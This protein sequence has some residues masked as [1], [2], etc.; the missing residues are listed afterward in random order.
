MVGEG[1][2][3]EKLERR[4]VETAAVGVSLYAAAREGV[5]EKQIFPPLS[6]EGF[7][8][9]QP[10]RIARREDFPIKK[11]FPFDLYLSL[12]LSYHRSL[13]QQKKV[14]RRPSISYRF[15]NALPI[16]IKPP[17]YFELFL[18]N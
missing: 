12:P 10:D 13:N 14:T 18:P 1:E 4:K 11:N 16:S 5:S 7:K 15:Q 2:T 9:L 17:H 3:R 8:K 6:F